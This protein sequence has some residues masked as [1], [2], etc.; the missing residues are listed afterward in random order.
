M[1]RRGN[2]DRI[3]WG[4]CLDLLILRPL[5]SSKV[6]ATALAHCRMHSW[7]EFEKLRRAHAFDE[8]SAARQFLQESMKELSES[9]VLIVDDAPANVDMLVNA[10]R[11]EHQLSVALD[12]AGALRA[13]EK[14]PPISS[15]STS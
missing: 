11:G 12:G 3:E 8:A 9:R 14:V 15:C 1:S 5:S 10:L 7:L 2:G 6:S 13:I 4:I